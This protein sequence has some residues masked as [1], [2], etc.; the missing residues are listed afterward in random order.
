MSPVGMSP[1]RIAKPFRLRDIDFDTD[2]PVYLMYGSA[3]RDERHFAD[4]DT[5]DIR[6]DNSKSIPFGAGP[7]FCAGAWASR[8]MV[9]GVALPTIFARLPNLHLVE[10]PNTMFAGWA[11]RGLRDLWISWDKQAKA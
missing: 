10:N 3:N 2:D 11:F 4:A 8:A 6:R 5:F 7:H 9:A 1:R